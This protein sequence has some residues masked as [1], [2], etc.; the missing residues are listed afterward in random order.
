V[1][2]ARLDRAEHAGQRVAHRQRVEDGGVTG[3]LEVDVEGRLDDVAVVLQVLLGQPQVLDQ[4]A[5]DEVAD[6]GT[7]GGLDAAAARRRGGG[8]AQRSGLRLGGLLAADVALLGHP[9]EDLVAALGGRLGV[10]ERV[11]G[12]GALR[13]AGEEGGLRQRERGGVD[14]EEGPGG[15]LD[16]VGVLPEVHDVEVAGEDL[17]LA[18]GVLERQRDPRLPELAGH[19]LLGG[20]TPLLGGLGDLQQGLLDQ[21][22]GQRR[23][24]LLHAAGGQV[25]QQRA[26]GALDVE[27]VV[28]VEAGVLDGDHRL[29]HDL[30]DLVVLH[31]GAVLVVEPGD[32]LTV[33][34]EQHGVGRRGVDGELG[35]QIAEEAGRPLRGDRRTADP[36]EEERRD[37]GP[38]R[39]DGGGQLEQRAD[40]AVDA[41]VH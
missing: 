14:A 30:G 24:A 16:A 26:H 6:E 17:V 29:L 8:E 18:V 21:L 7:H 19:R 10:G 13:E 38:C 31:R 3:A 15:R 23:P 28:V 11:V 25:G 36:R 35:G 41:P 4:V 12:G 1:A 33:G 22:L 40:P 39:Q 32:R 27:A 5:L 9:G 20:R 34:R 37:E 2:G